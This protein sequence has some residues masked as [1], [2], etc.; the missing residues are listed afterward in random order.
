MPVLT[1]EDILMGRDKKY[2]NELTSEIR[3]NIN[4]LLNSVNPFI[5]KCPYEC[6]V[7]SGWRPAAINSATSGAATKSTHL[8]G[9]AVDIA[10]PKGDLRRWVLCNLGGLQICGL[11]CEDFRWTPTWVHFQ[12]VSPRSGR[13]IYIPSTNPPLLPNAWSGRYDTNFDQKI[14]QKP[15]VAENPTVA[16]R[17]AETTGFLDSI[18]K[19]ILKALEGK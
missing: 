12:C 11:W 9:L 5:S 3:N 16:V 7:N 8:S 4:L 19:A 1:V 17:Q 18:L 6:H 13:R 14:Q 15:V 2:T 10:D